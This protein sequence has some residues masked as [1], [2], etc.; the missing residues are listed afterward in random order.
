MNTPERLTPLEAHHFFGVRFNNRVWDLLEQE[1]R[2]PQEDDE[3]RHAAHASHIHWVVAGKEVNCQRGNWMLARVYAELG[4]GESADHYAAECEKLTREYPD[5][6]EDFDR[7]YSAEA[8]ARAAAVQ[9]RH[10]EAEALFEAAWEAMRKIEKKED[11]E[12]AKADLNGGNWGG[13]S[14]R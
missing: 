3:M 1:K 14:H 11:R 2:T 10:E 7:F 6:M 9:G 12:I 8:Q 13:F 5:Q 4:M